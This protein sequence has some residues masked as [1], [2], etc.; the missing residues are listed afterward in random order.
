ME[1]PVCGGECSEMALARVTVNFDD[2]VDYV[3]HQM[4]DL[5]YAAT[6]EEINLVL[7]IFEEYLGTGG[8]VNDYDEDERSR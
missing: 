1:C 5:G 8:E 3:L 2:A 6:E 7:T 4:I